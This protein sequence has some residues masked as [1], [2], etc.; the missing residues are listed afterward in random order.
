MVAHAAV[1]FANKKGI[2]VIILDHHEKP[3]RLPKAYAIVHTTELCASGIAYF[4]AKEIL[5]PAR[6]T[7][8][9]ELA[10]IATI[11]DLLPLVGPNRSIVK[12]GLEA[13]RDTKRVGL[14][15]LFNVAGIQSVGTYEIGY[16]IGPRLNASGR[17]E[18]AKTA[19]DLLCATDDSLEEDCRH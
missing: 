19:L 13:L 6:M 4:V 16:L 3:R 2:D 5:D 12:Y 14:R 17:I 10:A 8:K 1:D 15:A 11:T 7:N 18:N 9:L